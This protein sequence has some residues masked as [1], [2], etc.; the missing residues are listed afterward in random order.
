MSRPLHIEAIIEIVKVWCSIDSNV[1]IPISE[2]DKNKIR[3]PSIK[4][5][6]MVNAHTPLRNEICMR[7]TLVESGILLLMVW[8]PGQAYQGPRP[9]PVEGSALLKSFEPLNSGPIWKALK[10]GYARVSP[11]PRCSN[12]FL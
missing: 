9:C 10:G 7:G 8:A 11:S 5:S 3:D 12:T 6:P 2:R 1:E 4:E